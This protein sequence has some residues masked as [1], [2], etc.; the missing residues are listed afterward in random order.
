VDSVGKESGGREEYSGEGMDNPESA[1]ESRDSDQYTKKGSRRNANDFHV[2]C[3]C[4]VDR[5]YSDAELKVLGE[6]IVR[7]PSCDYWKHQACIPGGYKKSMNIG[8]FCHDGR[9]CHRIY[10]PK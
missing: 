1:E 6:D 8:S 4:G 7:C 2:R 3:R 5:I 9:L 10:I